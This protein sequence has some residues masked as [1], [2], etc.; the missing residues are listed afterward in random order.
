VRPNYLPDFQEQRRLQ[1]N[2]RR[3]L[4]LND[5]F[6]ITDNS[7]GSATV[8][9][10]DGQSR[11][12]YDQMIKQNFKFTQDNYQDAY[13][14]AA[15]TGKAVVAIFGGFENNNS[16]QLIENALPEAKNGAA[17]DAVY[18]YIDRAKCKDP[19]MAKLADSQLAGGH[20]AAISLVFGVK[21]GKDGSIQPDET[22]FRWQGAHSSMIGSFNEAIT[23]AQD[24]TKSH[25]GQFDLSDRP[26]EQTKPNDSR[27]GSNDRT[28]PYDR[29]DANKKPE[30]FG[31]KIERARERIFDQITKAG[32]STDWHKAESNYHAAIDAADQFSPQ[33]LQTERARIA[34]ALRTTPQG[35]EKFQQLEHDANNL[36]FIENAKTYARAD[37]GVACLRWADQQP[38]DDL[39]H[40]FR[41]V[42]SQW[43]QSAA[44]RD[45]SV[46]AS[47]GLRE[48]IAETNISEVEL[49][50]L[51]PKFQTS[52][53]QP[54]LYRFD[55][56]RNGQETPPPPVVNNGSSDQGA[57]ASRRQQNTQTEKPIET[58]KVESAK[59]ETTNTGDAP[60]PKE[61]AEQEQK[62]LEKEDEDKAVKTEEEYNAVLRDAAAKGLPVIVKVGATYCGPCKKMAP[63][64]K[65]AEADFKGRAVIVR[66]LQDTTPELADKLGADEGIPITIVAGVVAKNN[67]QPSLIAFKKKTG[68]KNEQDELRSFV[69]AGLPLFDQW[70]RAQNLKR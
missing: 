41:Q 19:E 6:A 5:G 39:K 7:A 24:K 26:N 31:Q 29:T 15:R 3:P 28:E 56:N 23:R 20:N 32:E 16:R 4:H 67:E 64:L 33:S 49:K 55:G 58:A 34:Q 60:K 37:L 65:Q 8:I 53:R 54:D 2:N 18:V 22:N 46:Y 38:T 52:A 51:L 69:D 17:K 35:S 57:Q 10:V 43:I 62:R 61:S 13:K 66:V 14:E 12:D 44:N 45:P 68:F 42:G 25:E 40:K 27:R 70:K 47:E 36:R 1:S 9:A 59:T 48:R 50:E 11:S 63:S 30:S 21:P